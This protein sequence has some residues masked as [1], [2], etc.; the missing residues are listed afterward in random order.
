M[1]IKKV[2]LYEKNYCFELKVNQ[3]L[4]EPRVN[5]LFIMIIHLY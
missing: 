5:L 1:M 3:Y 2:T 4:L